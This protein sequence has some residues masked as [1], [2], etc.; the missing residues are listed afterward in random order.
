MRG[1]EII[2]KLEARYPLHLAM[3]KDNVGCLI[4][5]REKEVKRIYLAV[6]A[7]L[8]V[9][10]D[11]KK[12]KADLLITHHPLLFFPVGK[13]TDETAL[14]QV[15]LELIESQILY[16]AI[17][18]NYDAI[19]MGVRAG[20]RLGLQDMK[21]I[22]EMGEGFGIGVLG[23]LPKAISLLELSKRT[24][25]VFG[26]DGVRVFGDLDKKVKK[27]GVCPGSGRR[28]ISA[29]IEKGAEVLISG[30]LG[31]HDGV[32]GMEQGLSLIDA[33]HYGMEHIFLEDMKEECNRLFPELEVVQAPISH[34]YTSI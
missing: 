31:H 23:E 32:D 15:L 17:H 2:E 12:K 4:G 1:T 33:G 26:L 8:E 30:D 9:V 3:E 18:T 24:K 25:E 19:S 20:E 14:G 29:S 28:F 13:I 11:A 5:R 16:Y 10:R 27:I 7:T 6:D 21:P 22:E 34:P